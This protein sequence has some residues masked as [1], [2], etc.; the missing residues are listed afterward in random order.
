MS[1]TARQLA[2]CAAL[3]LSTAAAQ[4]GPVKV[5]SGW[6]GASCNTPPGNVTK[7]VRSVCDGQMNCNYRVDVTDLGDP[8]PNCKK[9][10]IVLFQCQGD[11]RVRLG[12]INREANERSVSLNCNVSN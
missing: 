3:L 11:E 10:F 12:Q 8:A 7:L 9:N 1:I 4:A 2:L 5:L 6:Y